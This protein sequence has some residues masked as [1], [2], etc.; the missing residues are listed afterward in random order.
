MIGFGVVG[1]KY[2]FL[3]SQG[4][5]LFKYPAVLIWFVGEGVDL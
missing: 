5:L 4:L 1:V 2:K 3:V